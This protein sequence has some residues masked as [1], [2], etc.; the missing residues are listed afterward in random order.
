M[1]SDQALAN[2]KSLN[3]IAGSRGQTLAQ[4][5]LA[6]V[7]R[8]GRVTTALI[9]ASKASQVIDCA[10]AVAN[11]EFSADELAQIDSY[12][13]EAD[14]NEPFATRDHIE[15]HRVAHKHIKRTQ[16]TR[17]FDRIGAKDWVIQVNISW[18]WRGSL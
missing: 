3:E 2:I 7:L 18:H 14:I 12:A 16:T 13:N 5:A 15:H 9:G 10:G 6:W 8:E 4:M 11:L 17:R 1:L